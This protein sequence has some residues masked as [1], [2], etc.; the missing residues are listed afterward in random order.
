[1]IPVNISPG[2]AASSSHALVDFE[3]V[4]AKRARFGE[5]PAAMGVGNAVEADI[6]DRRLALADQDWRS[7]DE[8]AVDQIGGEKGSGSCG[9]ALDQQIVDVMKSKD[10]FRAAEP[11]PSFH[12]FAASEQGT[13]WRAVLKPG[14]TDVEPGRVGEIGAAADQDH[15]RPC[16]LEMD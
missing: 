5:P 2:L 11:D 6:A 15:V 13:S 16:P 14:K 10:L 1:M 4:D 8:Q 12:R 3:P 7:I 9:A